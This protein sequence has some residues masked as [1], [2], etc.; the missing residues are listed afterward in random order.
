MSSHAPYKWSS[1]QQ[2]P[3]VSSSGGWYPYGGKLMDMEL[4]PG[5]NYST[6]ILTL[7]SPHHNYGPG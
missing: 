1:N 4:F 6:Q 5:Y 3:L 2:L 7:H